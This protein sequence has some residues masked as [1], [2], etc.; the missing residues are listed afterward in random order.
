MNFKFLGLLLLLGLAACAQLPTK[1]DSEKL[2]D[3]AEQ[4]NIN[5]SSLPMQELT[6]PIL[7]D[8]LLA[9]TALQRGY[10]EIAINNYLKLAQT[11]R[12]P[13]IA[14][15]ATEIALRLRQPFA[16]ENAVSLWTEL[17]PG[18]TNA[19][20][21]AA[22]LLVNMDRLDEARPHLK[23]L[24]ASEENE[25]DQAFMQLNKLLANNPNKIESLKLIQQLAEPYP[26]LPAAHFAVSQAAWLASQ[27]EIALDAMR[28]ALKIRP[29]WEMAAVYQGQILQRMRSKDVATYY[30][31]YLNKYPKAN[32][33][34]ASFV[35]L[36]ITERNFD[37]AREQLQQLL[38][39]N[40]DNADVALTIGLLSMELRD[41]NVTEESL[42]K[43]LSLGYKDKSLVYFHLA[44]IY[45]ETQRTDLAL[46]SYHK[47]KSGDRFF[48]AQIRYAALLA[49]KGDIN[50]AR[51]HLQHL[52]VAN[53]QQKAHLI[54][55]EAQLLRQ[56]GS[57]QQVFD[58][59]NNGL[60]QLPDFPELL[61]DRALAADK[62]GK[63]DILEKDLR[64]LI[65]LKPNSAHAYNALGYSLAERGDRLPEALQLIKKAVALSPE[66]AYIMDSLGWVYYRMGNIQEGL[67]YLNMAF[68]ARPDPEIAAHLG[69]VLWV[70][71]AKEDAKKIWQSALRDNPDNEVLLQTME[72]LMRQ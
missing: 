27:Y 2:E 35:R 55:A 71:G 17:D 30:E 8:F 41:F 34:R 69:E 67:N 40:P 23:M 38:E 3:S 7:F 13:R 4:A 6:A 9:E 64:K 39:E 5:Q 25:V 68:A 12:D 24:L 72:R 63:F 32:E 43:A 57:H 62:I 60:K 26:D 50:A 52:P 42:K 53:D 45:E 16:A 14:Q 66:D 59:L 20:Q 18:S 1:V 47:V 11:T 28:Q 10:P 56:S 61:Y 65:Q 15:R 22:A 48:P 58:L 46:T 29:D 70:K 19:H 37:G 51:R 31:N 21:A 49:Q 44:Q 33:M 54:L 36:L